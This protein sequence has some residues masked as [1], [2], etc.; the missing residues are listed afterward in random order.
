MSSNVRIYIAGNGY[1]PSIQTQ[2]TEIKSI[3]NCGFSLT[4]TSKA[5]CSA[6]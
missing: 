6:Y 2:V 1:Q 3:K 4:L 5:K